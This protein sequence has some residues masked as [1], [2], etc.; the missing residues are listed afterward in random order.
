MNDRNASIREGDLEGTPNTVINTTLSVVDGVGDDFLDQLENVLCEVSVLG[1]TPSG[2]VHVCREAIEVVDQ[3]GRASD[4][5][6][7]LFPMCADDN[8][9]LGLL[10]QERLQL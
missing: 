7:R 6:L 2:L 10:R 8:E 4:G 5:H 9:R 1:D 3:L